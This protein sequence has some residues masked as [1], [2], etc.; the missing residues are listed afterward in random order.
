LRGL[1]AALGASLFAGNA[2]ALYRSRP[3]STKA[4]TWHERQSKQPQGQRV[5]SG[6]G[7]ELKRLPSAV[8][9]VLGL[10]IFA[11]AMASLFSGF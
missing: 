3:T 9:A 10:L 7:R 2:L 8:M 5:P 4:P 1:V 6:S 11:W